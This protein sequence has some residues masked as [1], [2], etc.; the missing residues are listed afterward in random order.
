MWSSAAVYLLLVQDVVHSDTL[1]CRHW[2]FSVITDSDGI[3][4]NAL[5]QIM[6]VFMN[7]NLSLAHAPLSPR[8]SPA[9]VIL[10]AKKPAVDSLNITDQLHSLWG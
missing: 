4:K 3:P 6:P 2:L 5:N 10:E 7:F 1:P 9:P 8:V